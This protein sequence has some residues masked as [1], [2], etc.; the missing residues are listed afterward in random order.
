MHLEFDTPT[1]LYFI[2]LGIDKY[3]ESILVLPST[4]NRIETTEWRVH[5]QPSCTYDPGVCLTFPSSTK[6]L[7]IYYNGHFQMWKVV[8]VFCKNLLADKPNWGSASIFIKHLNIISTWFK[9]DS[10][11]IVIVHLQR[12]VGISKCSSLILSFIWIATHIRTI[13]ELF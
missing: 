11:H 7:V 9:G 2:I 3:F 5:P 8:T 13:W 12:L 10:T 6:Y 1:I 4:E